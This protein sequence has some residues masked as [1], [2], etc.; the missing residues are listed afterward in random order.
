[1]LELRLHDDEVAA[2]GRLAD[3]L[4]RRHCSVESDAFQR[5]SPVWA[6]ELPRRLRRELREF[7]LTEAAPGVVVSGWPVDEA[8]LAPTPDEP[9]PPA[10]P[11]PTLRH[12]VAFYLVGC[13]LGEPVGWATQQEGRLMHDVRPVRGFEHEQIGWGSE[14][15]LA[16]HTEDAF[17]PLRADYLGLLCLRNPDGVAT[18][19]GYVGDL[20]LTADVREVL[21]QE[22]FP[23][24]PDQAHRLPAHD[25][26]GA[27][28][29]REAR[30]RA[31][32]IE[33]V[34]RALS[35]P[36]PVAVLFGDVYDPYIR[37]D[38]HYMR[39]PE[40]PVEQVALRAAC[41]A[42]D[43]VLTG[44]PLC[45]GDMCFIDNHRAV[46]GRRSFRARF[47]GTDRWLRRL[48]ITRDL[49]RSRASRAGATSR[50]IY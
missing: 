11:S 22:R 17:H 3:E 47:D 49:R 25:G 2:I 48:N 24:L 16:W 15:V 31:H 21:R 45:P 4:T 20:E 1:M 5:E 7:R 42:M 27:L 30:L 46:H 40:D 29:E 23:V 32:S 50:V 43:S 9:W 34:E 19:V 6:E 35:D 36:E 38:P 14:E 28:E 39:A 37:L 10:G 8:E 13:L 41:A 26:A 33:R 18:T 44:V 12:D